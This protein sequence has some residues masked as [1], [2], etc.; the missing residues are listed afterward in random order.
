MNVIII[1]ERSGII[2]E[3]FIEKGHKA[4]SCDLADTETPGPHIIA[5]CRS[6][7]YSRFDLLIAHPPCQYLTK[8][9]GGKFWNEH[10]LEQ[11]EAVSFVLWIWNLPV[12]R[13]RTIGII[14]PAWLTHQA[15]YLYHAG[16]SVI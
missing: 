13:S 5:D 8:A 14:K 15:G 9:G 3:A 1:C 11:N 12:E 16:Y 4:V 6:L 2:R 10:R 7:D